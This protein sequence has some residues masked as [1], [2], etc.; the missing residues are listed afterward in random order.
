MTLASNCSSSSG[1]RAITSVLIADP[2]S[3]NASQ[4]GISSTTS[5]RLAR[6]TEVAW[7]RLRRS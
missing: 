2:A 3:R 7:A 6:M 4:S 1:S 5:A